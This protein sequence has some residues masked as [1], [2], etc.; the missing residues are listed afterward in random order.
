LNVDASIGGT[1]E[2]MHNGIDTVLW[3]ASA[4]SGTWVFDSTAQ[5]QSGIKSIDATATTNN[6]TALLTS[7]ST[8]TMSNYASLTGWV[9]IT[10]WPTTGTKNVRLQFRNG[11]VVVGL[12]IDLSNYVNTLLFNT[13]QKFII[14]LSDFGVAS[15]SLIDEF[16]ITSIDSGSGAAPDYYLD[17]IQLEQLGGNIIYSINPD[18][19]DFWDV[20]SISIT[21]VRPY[22]STLT[23]G[24]MI[25]IPYDGLLGL[26]TLANG[27]NFQRIQDSEVAFSGLVKDFIDVIEALGETK[28]ITGSDGVNTWVKVTKIFP[29]A[30]RLVGR[31]AD[32]LQVILSDDLSSFT[33]FR[34][35]ANIKE[36]SN[37]GA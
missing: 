33:R 31:N 35:S 4:L 9:Y 1:P 24:T 7:G 12:Q 6:D 13:W 15:T 34:I 19:D 32:R 2:Q 28:I 29:T 30:F 27:I 23:N 21:M 5:A 36:Y 14:P 20:Q 10:S 16:T 18:S 3:T 11:G 8:I 26:G 22:N 37:Y 25:N 17:N